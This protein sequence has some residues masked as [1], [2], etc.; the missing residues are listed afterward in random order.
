M[1]AFTRKKNIG[2]FIFLKVDTSTIDINIHPNKIEI[3]F[4][5]DQSLYSIINSTVKH[6]LGIFQVIPTIDFESKTK[7]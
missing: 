3:R 4:E 2:F 1:R 7:F 6:S 5:D